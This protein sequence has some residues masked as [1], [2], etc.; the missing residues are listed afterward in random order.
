VRALGC[1]VLE[2]EQLVDTMISRGY[3]SKEELPEQPT[4]WLIKAP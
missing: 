3:L 1:S 2:G 4:R